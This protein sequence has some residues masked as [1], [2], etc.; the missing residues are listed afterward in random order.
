METVNA[1]PMEVVFSWSGTIMCRWSCSR[2]LSVSGRQISPRPYLAMKLTASGVTRSAAMHRS[3]SFSRS[4][5]S[6]RI[7]MRPARISSIASETATMTSL[8]SLG[9]LDR[10]ALGI[11]LIGSDLTYGP[12]AGSVGVERR[13]DLRVRNRRYQRLILVSIQALAPGEA[14]PRARL[15]D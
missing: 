1:V 9:K 11:P 13:A 14:A 7:T 2:R 8:A 12:G 15:E 5:S 6:T 10:S 3:P 4:S